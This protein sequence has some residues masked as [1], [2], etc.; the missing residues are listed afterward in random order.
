LSFVPQNRDSDGMIQE[1]HTVLNELHRRPVP[2]GML[3]G[4]EVRE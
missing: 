2:G 3:Q 1:I 4:S